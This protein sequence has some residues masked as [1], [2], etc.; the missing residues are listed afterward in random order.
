MTSGTIFPELVQF[1]PESKIRLWGD[2]EIWWCW[3]KHPAICC[4]KWTNIV[5]GLKSKPWDFWWLFLR[6]LF[7]VTMVSHFIF[8]EMQNGNM[9]AQKATSAFVTLGHHF[10]ILLF[11]LSKEK[12]YVFWQKG[13]VQYKYVFIVCLSTFS[14]FIIISSQYLSFYYAVKMN[15]NPWVN[16]GRHEF[17]PD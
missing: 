16:S 11:N 6:A 15:H 3:K 4:W 5:F 8:I 1:V 2:E 10:G 12:N 9:K 13:S 17:G 7:T 14:L